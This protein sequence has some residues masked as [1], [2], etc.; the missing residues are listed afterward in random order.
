MSMDEENRKKLEAH[1]KKMKDSGGKRLPG[2]DTEN[3]ADGKSA[4][5]TAG[6]Y[7]QRDRWEAWK[8]MHSNRMHDLNA[9]QPR[10]EA[11]R[12]DYRVLGVKANA[13]RNEV[14]KAYF[15]LA[16]VHHP[17]AGG[18]PERFQEIWTAYNR[19]MDEFDRAAP[20]ED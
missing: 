8:R 16:K 17:D 6:D 18:N 12:S 14:K 1:L 20:R 10:V 4:D 9:Q 5:Y 13:D 3:E 2:A 11:D 19:I 7:G 15:K